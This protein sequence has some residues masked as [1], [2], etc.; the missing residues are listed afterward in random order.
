M[1]FQYFL[2]YNILNKVKCKNNLQ[3]IIKNN[4]KKNQIKEDEM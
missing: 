1:N 3:L 4:H 2:R